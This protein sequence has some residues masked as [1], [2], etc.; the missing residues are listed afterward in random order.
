MLNAVIEE[1][2]LLNLNRLGLILSELCKRKN[3]CVTSL[4]NVMVAGFV[5]FAGAAAA[6][7]LLC[8]VDSFIIFRIFQFSESVGP[9]CLKLLKCFRSQRNTVII[10]VDKILF[11]F[12]L[13]FFLFVWVFWGY[14]EPTQFETH[15][16]PLQLSEDLITFMSML[17]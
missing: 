3:T 10:F 7:K 12:Q 9:L 5:G 6:P 13:F 17:A 11:L 15:F 2:T 4:K 16:R 8:L 1:N 14:F